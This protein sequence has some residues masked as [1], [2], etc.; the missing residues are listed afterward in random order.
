MNRLLRHV[1]LLCLLGVCAPSWSQGSWN[2]DYNGD[3]IITASDLT[4]FL[5]AWEMAVDSIVKSAWEVYCDDM[6][7]GLVP[8]DS[9]GSKKS[10]R[11]RAHRTSVNPLFSGNSGRVQPSGTCKTST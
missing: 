3:G 5:T 2:P 8:L 7:E 4:G 6:M 9:R 1:F 11:P 10:A